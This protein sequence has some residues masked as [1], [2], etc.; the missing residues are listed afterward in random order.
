VIDNASTKR[1]L[2]VDDEPNV[3]LGLQRLLRA[4][5]QEW[6]MVFVNSGDEALE[7]LTREKFNVIVSDLRMPRMGGIQ[8]LEVVQKKYP[9]M[10]RFILSGNT[11]TDLILQSVNAAHQFLAKPCDADFLQQAIARAFSLRELFKSSVIS[12][13]VKDGAALPTLPDLYYKLS[14]VLAAPDSS[15]EMIADIIS[16]DVSMSAKILQ[17]VNSAFFGL[18]RRVDSISHAVS[19]LGAETIN[20]LLLTT[21]VFS[22]FDDD[23]V[24]RFGIRQIYAHSLRVGEFTARLV[25]TAWNDRKKADEARL[26]GMVHDLGKLVFINNNH[27]EW[28]KIYLEQKS[29]KEPLYV[30][31]KEALGI[32]HAEVGAYLLTLWGLSNHVVE[33]VAF[34]HEPSKAPVKEFGTL[35]ALHLANTMDVSDGEPRALDLDYFQ[36]IGLGDKIEEYSSL[37]RLPTAKDT[38]KLG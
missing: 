37:C 10:I 5:R 18:S 38:E 36:A 11:N 20:S 3:L 6:E 7:L 14:A 31:E 35:A 30:L 4:Y 29:R 23:Q 26:A 8:L 9:E 12:S 28:A 16:R 22:K 2:F 17:L 24:E 27:R 19:L 25:S 1:I 33:A 15:A 21:S 13:I 32:S 34:H